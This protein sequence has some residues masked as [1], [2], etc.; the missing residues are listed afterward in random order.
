MSTAA[1]PRTGTELQEQS[2]LVAWAGTMTR[3]HPELALLYA[4]P[5]GHAVGYKAGRRANREGRRKGMPDLCLP[6]P[7]GPYHALYVEMKTATGR[8]TAEQS[9]VHDELRTYGNA[10]VVARGWD[11][12]RAAILLYLGE[13]G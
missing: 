10:V 9:A 11:E 6:V 5:N 2:A 13:A 1:R 7:G 3:V 8:V 4:I 12:A